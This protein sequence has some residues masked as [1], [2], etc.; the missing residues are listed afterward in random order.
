MTQKK[1]D[2][3]KKKRRT[4]FC[5]DLKTFYASVECA[6]RQLDPFST[7]LVVADP[8]RGKGAICLAVS[9][10]LK[11]LGV[12]NR[13]RLYEIPEHIPYRIALPRMSL[14]IRY[15]ARIYGIYLRFI[16]KEDIHVY[17]IDEAFLDATDYLRLYRLSP[18]NL[19]QKMMDTV[20]EETGIPSACGIGSNLYLAKV[21]LD[22]LAKHRENRIAVLDEDSYRD[23]L[24]RHR[25][26]TDF[27]QIG[28]GIARRLENHGFHYMEDI[29]KGD[30]RI[31]YKLLGINAEYLIDHANGIE[32]CTIKEIQ[33]YKVES[34]SVSSGQVLFEDYAYEKAELVVKEMV[35]L[36]CLDLSGRHLV[37]SRIGLS[38]GYSKDSA[39]KTGGSVK[40]TNTT[41]SFRL[42]LP[43]FLDLY[44]KTTRK[45]GKI[46]KITV[47]FSE[48]KDEI[49]EQY[50]LFVDTN[51]VLKDARLQK[52]LVK[53]KEKYGKNAVMRGMN[54]EEGATTPKRNKLIGGHNGE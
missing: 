24:W 6:I 42:L 54:L 19:A 9:P 31:L 18:E 30:P 49:Y 21:A 28:K 51:E 48:V 3:P 33:S 39:P 41:N 14:Y 13:C 38:I 15:S 45:E 47:F 23:Q 26:L 12:K 10:H 11:E 40:L 2:S 16:A 22:I 43:H 1:G 7:D 27:W 29:A 50:D 20:Y 5:I 36:A 8:S 4:Y 35:E 17:S 34:R 37:A 52:T 32:P 46:R 53:I 25:P 44:R